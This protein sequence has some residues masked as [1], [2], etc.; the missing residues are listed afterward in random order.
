MFFRIVGAWI[1]VMGFAAA[2]NAQHLEPQRKL[3]LQW[4][5]TGPIATWTVSID[6]EDAH[7]MMAMADVNGNGSFEDAESKVLAGMLTARAR[8]GVH[9]RVNGKVIVPAKGS[10]FVLDKISTREKLM[11]TGTITWDLP[12]MGVKEA[13][14]Y[15]LEIS[16]AGKRGVLDFELSGEQGDTFTEQSG[17]LTQSAAESM[18]LRRLRGGQRLSVLVTRGVTTFAEGLN[19]PR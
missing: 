10:E 11:A 9:L 12:G 2:V 5:K 1:A 19:T 16:L 3:T 13:E 4:Q 6:G 8:Y 7:I 15:M 14:T 17:E 18:L